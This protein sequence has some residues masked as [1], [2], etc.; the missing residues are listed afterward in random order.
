[1]KCFMYSVPQGDVVHSWGSWSVPSGHREQ[2]LGTAHVLVAW[3]SE[4]F[5]ELALLDCCSASF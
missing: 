3:N 5:G 2:A 1:M 4:K